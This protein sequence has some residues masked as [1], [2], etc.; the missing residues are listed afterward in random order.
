MRRSQLCS[1]YGLVVRLW[2][3]RV[4]LMMSRC[5]RVC[6]EQCLR[7]HGRQAQQ[8]FSRFHIPGVAKPISYATWIAT[9]VMACSLQSN[10][11]KASA[12][13]KG[14][15]NAKATSD[16][17]KLKWAG[18]AVEAG[19]KLARCAARTGDEDAGARLYA[20]N[21]RSRSAPESISPLL[22]ME[23]TASV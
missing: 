10:P 2:V 1:C 11:T 5:V 9:T 22:T 7:V 6:A 14:I 20:R 16:P 15:Q 3:L 13:D 21:E 8:E 19:D 4:G 18:A 23:L 12:I 17:E